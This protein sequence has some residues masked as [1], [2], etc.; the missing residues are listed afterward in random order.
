MSVMAGFLLIMALSALAFWLYLGPAYV[1]HRRRHPQRQ[2]ILVL[3]LL[4]GWTLIAWVV[5]M[6]WACTAVDQPEDGRAGR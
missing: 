3:N 2:A 1:A 5:A 4:A 6:V